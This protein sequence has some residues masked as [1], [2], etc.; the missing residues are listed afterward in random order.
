MFSVGL[1]GR[2]PGVPCVLPVPH[3]ASVPNGGP[4]QPSHHS[5]FPLSPDNKPRD[6]PFVYTDLSNNTPMHNNNN[7]TPMH[8]NNNNHKL[9]GVHTM[10]QN[11][12]HTFGGQINSKNG[13]GRKSHF[14]AIRKSKN[15]HS[16]AGNVQ[17][18]L[19]APHVQ[20]NFVWKPYVS[21]G[22]GNSE[23]PTANSNGHRPHEMKHCS[24]N[25]GF[26]STS[27]CSCRNGV[28]WSL[29]HPGINE[30]SQ[31]S[32]LSFLF[33]GE[34]DWSMQN[35]GGRHGSPTNEWACFFQAG[36]KP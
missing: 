35:G 22:E 29:S 28:N 18:C 16:Y 11:E 13:N 27:E 32:L 25:L 17:K 21:S 3:S 1:S 33:A 14:H 8:N 2:A 34:A 9:F 31:Q 15:R 10:P 19:D 30:E 24:C 12:H 6:A 26:N 23:A 4:V 20:G 36:K 5:A 7:N